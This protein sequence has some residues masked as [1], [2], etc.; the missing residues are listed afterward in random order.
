MIVRLSTSVLALI[1]LSWCAATAR[2]GSPSPCRLVTVAEVKAAFGGTV[3]P[4][5]VDTSLPSAPTCHFAV[6]ASN[7]GQSGEAVVFITPGQTPATFALAKKLVPGAVAVSGVGTAAFYNPH[8][9]SVELLEGG[10]VAS[11]Q[12]IFLNPGG[13]QPD[14]AKAK[15]DTIALAKAVAKHV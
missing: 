1:C 2:A 7:L 13:P 8:T 9:T 12:A 15:A 6:T 4:G 3:G 14:P 10:V 11:A 5:R